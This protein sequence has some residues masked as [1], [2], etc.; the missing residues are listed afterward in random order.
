M[1]QIYIDL[2]T[3]VHWFRPPVGI[4]RVEREFARYCFE[5][6]AKA[7]FC[8]VDGDG[9][10]RQIDR[11]MVRGVL[12]DSSR[13][14]RPAPSNEIASGQC[15]N[16]SP[17]DL[18]ISIGLQWHQ[19][20]AAYA[21]RLKQHCQLR[22]VEGAYDTIPIDYPE[23]S[24]NQRQQF[25][26]HFTCIAHTADLVF[27]ISET[28]RKDLSAFYERIGII[29]PPTIRTVY[30]A[31]P[32][33]HTHIAP[34]C[35]VEDE[36]F[37]LAR[38]VGSTYVLYVSS[39]EIRKNHR[40][41][42]EIWKAF[43]RERGEMCPLLV[44]IGMFGWNVDDLWAEMQVCEVWQAGKIVMLHD[45]TDAMLAHLYRGCAFTV[46]PSF[47]EGWGLATTES[48]AY[49]KLAIVSS[50]PA[51][52]EATRELCPVIHPL[53][54]PRWRDTIAYYLDNLN[55]RAEAESRIRTAFEPRHWSDFSAE[56]LDAAKA[57]PAK[58]QV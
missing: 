17:D 37:T 20:C 51:L 32:E 14:Y 13:Q 7:V 52:R 3:N 47:Y 45:V 56:L 31:V 23:Y 16:P 43:Y 8:A 54:F 27:T 1:A 39:F 2:T 18:F 36:R 30:L 15:I 58:N 48:F 19:N 4:V 46:F 11:C 50:A 41:L 53:D 44:I 6:E 35:L 22:V 12:D 26:E 38:L 10:Y 24:G 57:I 9:K 34:V 5:H 28:S 49:G 33:T 21:Y 25:A 42:L 55:A 29:N 40:L